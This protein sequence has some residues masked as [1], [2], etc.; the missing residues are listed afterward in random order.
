MKSKEKCYN[1]KNCH[2][3]HIPLFLIPYFSVFYASPFEV[4]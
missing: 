4:R 1:E 2:Y 3:F